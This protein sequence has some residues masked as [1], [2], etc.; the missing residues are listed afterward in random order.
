MTAPGPL[1]PA[2]IG[3][4]TWKMGESSSQ[5]AREIAAVNHALEVGYRLI[6]TAE[7]YGHGN[8]ERI[9]GTAL[10]SYGAGRRSEL[11]L[12][13]KVLPGNELL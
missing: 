10:R 13:T 2:R 9:V 4:G 11:Y 5:R 7:M 3:L 8:A 6:D 12:V 1:F